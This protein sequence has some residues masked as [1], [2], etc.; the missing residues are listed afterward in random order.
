MV[1]GVI[2][3]TVGP[4]LLNAYPGFEYVCR[5][6]KMSVDAVEG[7]EGLIGV[8]LATGV[9]LGLVVQSKERGISPGFERVPLC[10]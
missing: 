4:T 5:A 2:Y 10:R 6:D 9:Y 7:L 3:G 8:S 1:R